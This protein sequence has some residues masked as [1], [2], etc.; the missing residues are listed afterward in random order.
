MIGMAVTSPEEKVIRSVL[1]S[2]G[3]P[4]VTA[5]VWLVVFQYQWTPYVSVGR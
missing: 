5:I 2:E 1:A 4:A 3:F